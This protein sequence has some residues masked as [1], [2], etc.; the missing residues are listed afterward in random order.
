MKWITTLIVVSAITL[1]VSCSKEED[2]P[3]GSN[4]KQVSYNGNSGNNQLNSN[5]GSTIGSKPITNTPSTPSSHNGVSANC[6]SC[7][8][9]MLK[10]FRLDKTAFK[11]ESKAAIG[12]LTNLAKMQTGE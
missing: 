7:H 8:K 6:N 3:Q 9:G 1:I 11:D 5:G 12:A 4:T 2:A 10:D